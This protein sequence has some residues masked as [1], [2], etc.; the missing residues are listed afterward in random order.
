MGGYRALEWAVT[1]PERVARLLAVATTAA[2]TRGPDRRADRAAAGG[3][4]PTRPGAAATTPPARG[5]T[6]G[7]GLARRIAHL[8][9]RSGT[10]SRRGSGAAP[11][12]AR[13]ARR[14]PVRRAVLPRPP[15]RQAGPPLRRGQ[16]R[17]AHRGDE[18]PR[19]RPGPRRGGGRARPGHR[20]RPPSLGVDSDRLYPLEQQQRIADRRPGRRPA[21][22]G[23]AA[24][25]ATTASCSRPPPSGR[26]S[27]RCSTGSRQRRPAQWP[28]EPQPQRRHLQPQRHLQPRPASAGA[29]PARLPAR[30]A[31][32][33]RARPRRQRGRT[34]AAAAGPPGARRRSQDGGRAGRPGR[35]AGRAAARRRRARRRRATTCCSAPPRA[36]C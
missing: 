19:R 18:H 8:T 22:G 33:R 36:W 9:Y 25:T 6:A 12:T 30:P 35:P 3:H 20:A 34:A 13:T 32:G 28:G 27:A 15:R 2:A 14:R 10:S 29:V 24:R 21:A 31:G 4:R 1:R 7:L 17:H 5:P 16:L 23:R 26:P 11:R